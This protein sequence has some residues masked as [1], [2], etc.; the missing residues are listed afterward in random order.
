MS[1][2]GGVQK[3]VLGLAGQL[4]R[5][6]VRALVVAPGRPAEDAPA[7][8]V[9]LG[10]ATAFHDNGS[11][12][13]TVIDPLR[14]GRVMQRLKRG[15][16]VVHIH[17]P[18][19]PVGLS[20]IAGASGAVVAT[21]HMSA[22]DA[23]WY[24]RFAPIV[25]T[26]ASRIDARIAVSVPARDHVSRVLPGDYRV[27]PNAVDRRL[28]QARSSGSRPG[29]PARILFVGRPDPR[30]GLPVLM[31]A[32]ARLSNARLDIVG[33][34]TAAAAD[35]GANVRAHDRLSEPD[36]RRL[37]TAADIVC[38]PSIGGESFGLVVLEAMAAGTA[39]VASRIPAHARLLPADCG[40]LVAPGNAGALAATLAELTEDRPLL[41]RMG[42]RGREQARRYDW[43]HVIRA[44][45]DVYTA[46]TGRRLRAA[47]C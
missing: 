28:L 21:F 15:F 7:E 47:R 25:R 27:V 14:L 29:E 33:P 20:A 17:E 39:V 10:G 9:S 12:V 6:G 19:L 46:A 11:V 35:G 24:R 42:A 38:V 37:L 2:P 23:R 44:V 8:Y 22:R 1:H 5:A 32:F 13:R 18:M 30:K 31:R 41:R 36:L 40:R 26:A 16:D 4:R 45:A 43:D 3:Q 34:G